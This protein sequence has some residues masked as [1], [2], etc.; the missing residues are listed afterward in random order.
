[1]NSLK[2]SGGIN[3]GAEPF[4]LSFGVMAKPVVLIYRVFTS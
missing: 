1:M 3:G 4:G 2:H